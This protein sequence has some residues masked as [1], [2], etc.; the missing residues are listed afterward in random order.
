MPELGLSG[1]VRGARGNPRSYRDKCRQLNPQYR[2]HWPSPLLKLPR[3]GNGF[4][5]AR[6]LDLNRYPELPDFSH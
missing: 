1:S 3:I 4:A 6:G 5:F 2:T